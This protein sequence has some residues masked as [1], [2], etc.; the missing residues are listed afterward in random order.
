[1]KLALVQQSEFGPAERHKLVGNLVIALRALGHEAEARSP[2]VDGTGDLA[3][4]TSMAE[5]TSPRF[6]RE[7][8]VDGVIAV[9]WMWQSAVL[10]AAKEAGVPTVALADSDGTFVPWHHP[11][12]SIRR[13]AMMAENLVRRRQPGNRSAAAIEAVTPAGLA[14]YRSETLTQKLA[15]RRRLRA[16][17]DAATWT[18]LPGEPALRDTLRTLER[19]GIDVPP[20]S[21]GLSEQPVAE[22]FSTA[23]LGASRLREV[24]AIG[25]WDDPVK[26]PRLLAATLERLLA[27]DRKLTV[28]IVGPGS[29][30][31]APADPRIRTIDAIPNAE[32][33]ELLARA[34]VLLSTS[35]F[36]GG[37]MI[38]GEALSCGCAVAGPPLNAIEHLESGPGGWRAHRR[39]PTELA[40]AVESAL[41][42]STRDPG[43]AARV[44]DHWRP[45]FQATA[46]AAKLVARIEG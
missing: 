32:L 45:R 3:S 26:D 25:R 22:A 12:A 35:R 24:A 17:V 44:A 11:R 37:S 31:V 39:T 19:L 7:Q 43:F 15:V 16:S 18:G 23:P 4:A 2:V 10:A 6:W 34:S 29:G 33:P 46:V 27:G 8:S 21:M 20:G 41:A 38:F 1:M 30:S 42:A 36:E 28:T 13:A 5:L 40:R 14:E 9:T